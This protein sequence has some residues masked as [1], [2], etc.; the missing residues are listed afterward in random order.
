MTPPYPDKSMASISGGLILWI[1]TNAHALIAMSHWRDGNL[2]L[3]Q[4]GGMIYF[5]AITTDAL[6]S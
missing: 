4:V 3:G 1:K 2:V 6:I 5:F